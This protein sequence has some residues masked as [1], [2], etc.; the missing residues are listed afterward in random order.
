M[1]Y[2]MRMGCS[3]FLYQRLVSVTKAG[4]TAPSANPRANRTPMK[5]EKVVA[6]A[7]HYLDISMSSNKMLVTG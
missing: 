6:P 3:L 7:R 1:S 2:P 5:D 4:E